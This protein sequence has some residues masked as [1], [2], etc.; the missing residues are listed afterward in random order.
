MRSTVRIDDDLMQALKES[1]R[2]EGVSLSRALNRAVRSGLAAQN[3]V[4]AEQPFQQ[5]TFRLGAA[6]L[7]LDKALSIAAELENEEILGKFAARK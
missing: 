1:A 5:R 6:R 3:E 7:N 4:E 2:Q